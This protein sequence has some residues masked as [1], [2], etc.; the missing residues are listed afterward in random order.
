[1]T[2]VNTPSQAA[3]KNHKE[4]NRAQ[5]GGD[6]QPN[7]FNLHSIRI[8]IRVCVC[9]CVYIYIYLYI[10]VYMCR[11]QIYVFVCIYVQVDIG[12]AAPNFKSRTKFVFQS[13]EFKW[14]T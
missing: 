10:F 9:V 6:H 11:L 2:R 7:Y 13:G 14:T 4:K 5:V 1:M 8:Y 12:D 3:R